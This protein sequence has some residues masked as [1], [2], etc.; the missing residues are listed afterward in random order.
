MNLLH[1]QKWMAHASPE[2][3]L[4]YAR[5]LDETMRKSWEEATKQGLFRIDQQNKLKRIDITEIENLHLNSVRIK[6]SLVFTY[7]LHTMS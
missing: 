3:T 5:L 2:M 4:I 1:V 7:T 6:L